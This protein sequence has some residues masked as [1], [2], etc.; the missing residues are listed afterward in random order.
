MADSKPPSSSIAG[1]PTNPTPEQ[2]RYFLT[3]GPFLKANERP[4]ANRGMS[5]MSSYIGA[6]Q[7]LRAPLPAIALREHIQKLGWRPLL[8]RLAMLG[9]V[10]ANDPAGQN[11]EFIRTSV[12]EPILNRGK[13]IHDWRWGL[14]AD[15]VAANAGRPIVHEQVIYFLQALCILEGA[16]DGP[17]P[18]DLQVAWLCLAANDHLSGWLEADSRP[19]SQIEGP[20]AELCHVSRYNHYP[21]PLRNLVRASSMFSRKPSHGP[22]STDV[23]W[24]ELQERAFGSSFSAYFEGF[25]LPF[26]FVSSLWGTPHRDGMLNTPTIDIDRWLSRSQVDPAKGAQF[27]R[28]FTADRKT[29][30]AELRKRLRPDGLP[31]APTAF[32]KTPLVDIGEGSAIGT[33]PWMVREHLRGGLW[34]KMLNA[35]KKLKG[36]DVWKG[37]QAWSQS[38]G[39]MFESACHDLAREAKSIEGFRGAVELSGVPGSDEIEDVVVSDGKAVALFSA[40]S[41]LMEEPVARQARSR[42]LVLDW[43][44]DFMFAE[45]SV[46]N[47]QKFQPGVLRL[48][49]ANVRRVLSAR[50]P[51]QIYPVLLTFDHVGENGALYTWLDQKCKEL[52]LL[53]GSAVSPLTLMTI[54]E[55]ESLLSLATRGRSIIELLALKVT[56]EWRTARMTSF[57]HDN[58][59]GGHLRLPSMEPRFATLTEATHLRLFGRKPPPPD[60]EPA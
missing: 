54:D 23:A 43:Y 45:A 3:L 27:L 56:P 6:S 34:I 29:L 48:L 24:L 19:V 44:T 53:Q 36:A 55:F 26:V 50:P 40:K 17:E 12:N 58:Q 31:H 57:L 1:L 8:F 52:G 51:E 59:F 41:R 60:T 30:Q 46:K 9:A 39:L 2:L 33:S 20:V 38:F 49:D 16:E 42:T 35:S 4:T 28:S 10:L 11:S 22:Y 37:A 15:Y 21:D 7:I 47:G 25:V 13:T 14:V 5:H 32:I 18:T